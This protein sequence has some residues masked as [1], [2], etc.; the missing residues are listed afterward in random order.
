M[1]GHK[2]DD[3]QL[4]LRPFP[5]NQVGELD[6]KL[7]WRKYREDMISYA[8]IAIFIFGN[9]LVNDQILLSDGMKEE[10]EIAKNQGVFVVPVG[11]TGY[12]AE[13]LWVELKESIES[14]AL[15]FPEKIKVALLS[16]G[17][18]SMSL[19][20]IKKIILEIVTNISKGV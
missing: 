5:Q 15:S 4:L 6:L 9:K 20:N 12:M 2:L 11:A 17:D 14:G 3:D 16:L 8:G 10:Y 7:L 19:E 1:S 18:R 13:K